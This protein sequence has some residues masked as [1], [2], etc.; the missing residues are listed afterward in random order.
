MDDDDLRQ[1]GIPQ[2]VLRISVYM[3][4]SGQGGVV[5]VWQNTTDAP[6]CYLAPGESRALLAA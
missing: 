1:Y 3:W 6:V 5:L 4:V 2:Q